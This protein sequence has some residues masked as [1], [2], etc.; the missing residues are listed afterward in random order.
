MDILLQQQQKQ[1]PLELGVTGKDKKNA[2]FVWSPAA[3]TA[4]NTIK[5]QPLSAPVL[6]IP[7]FARPFRV[8]TDASDFAVAS[9]LMQES[10]TPTE[11]NYQTEQREALAVVWSLRI[12]KH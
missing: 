12:W 1:S 4:F 5:Q 3:D 6:A 10:P 2:R 9:C 7:D 11:Q 8:V